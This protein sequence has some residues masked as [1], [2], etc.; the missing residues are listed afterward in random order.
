MSQNQRFSL[1]SRGYRNGEMVSGGL[2]DFF[3]HFDN[4]YLPEQQHIPDIRKTYFHTLVFS[5]NW[6]ESRNS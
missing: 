6:K 4:C 1:V 3:Q 2:K 5:Y